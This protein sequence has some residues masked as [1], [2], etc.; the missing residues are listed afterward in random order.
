MEKAPTIHKKLSKDT[1]SSLKIQKTLRRH[2]KLPKHT[3]KA[4]KRHRKFAKRHRKG[5]KRTESFQD[6]QK[7]LPKFASFLNS[8]FLNFNNQLNHRK[9]L[10]DNENLHPYKSL[11]SLSLCAFRSG[12]K[13]FEVM[14]S[15]IATRSGLLRWK[16]HKNHSDDSLKP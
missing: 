10:L 15:F 4:F 5:S 8:W 2:K 13:M 1:E 9:H 12:F 6:T 7:T 11:I 3:Q 16:D 14:T